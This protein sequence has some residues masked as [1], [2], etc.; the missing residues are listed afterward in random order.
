M[1]ECFICKNSFWKKGSGIGKFNFCTKDCFN[2]W[3]YS[4][5]VNKEIGKKIGESEFHSNRPEFLNSKCFSIIAKMP[6]M[7]GECCSYP[8]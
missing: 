8:T 2:Q 6:C 3:R 4:P 1:V 7:A 5:E